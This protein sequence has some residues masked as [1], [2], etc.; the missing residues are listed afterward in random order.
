MDNSPSQ[1]CVH[2]DITVFPTKPL[3]PPIVES[4]IPPK[5]LAI[6]KKYKYNWRLEQLS[7]PKKQSRKFVPKEFK[8]IE[9]VKPP[10]RLCDEIKYYADQMAR[11]KLKNLYLN[12]RLFGH[13]TKG[14]KKKFNKNINKAW[15]SIYNYYKKREKERKERLKRREKMHKGKKPWTLD[16][17]YY[18]KLSKPKPCLKPEPK[19]KTSKI[20]ANFERLDELAAPKP[21]HELPLKSLEVNPHALT[22]E[23]TEAVLKLAQLPPRYMNQLPPLEPGF[24]RKSALRY[25]ASPRIIE[26]AQP[27]KKNEKS[28]VDEYF[29]PWA[30]SKNA[31]KY[32]AT[33]RIIELA[34]PVER[35]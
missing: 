18:D 10:P 2:M 29:D 8:G 7:K 20:F 4:P 14:I 11:P 24:V 15:D 9:Q 26:I 22:Y 13:L 16:K 27:K 25:N 32:K 33:P 31:L 17:N 3:P 30:I 35:D 23:P 34:K 6:M 28:K 12:R 5:L 1:E 21:S 19:K